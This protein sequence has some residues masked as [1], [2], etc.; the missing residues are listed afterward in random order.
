MRSLCKNCDK[1]NRSKRI[2][3][4]K[5]YDKKIYNENKE[6]IDERN[7]KWKNENNEQFKEYKRN[8]MK[9]KRSKETDSDKLKNNLRMRISKNIKKVNSTA[10]YL[11]TTIA[12]VKKWLENNFKEDMNWDNYGKLWNIDHTI[13]INAF[14]LTNE[15]HIFVCFNWRNL[16]PMYSSKNSGKRNKIVTA[17]ILHQELLC[18]S[19]C[20]KKDTV[21]YFLKYNKF[22]IDLNMRNIS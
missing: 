5:A 1:A 20:S 4:K 10:K 22:Y 8:Y 11:D 17:L 6:A 7:K 15:E 19:Y 18:K 16:M 12:D 13:P 2:E 21:D 9:E 3:E 14:D